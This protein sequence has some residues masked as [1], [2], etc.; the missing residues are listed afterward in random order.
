MTKDSRGRVRFGYRGYR[1]ELT[2]R[3]MTVYNRYVAYD[4]NNWRGRETVECYTQ[5][6]YRLLF[7]N[8]TGRTLLATALEALDT[9]PF[10]TAI[11]IPEHMRA[12]TSKPLRTNNQTRATR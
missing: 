10:T 7:G 9:S 6:P 11:H 3:G 8:V 12:V 5:Y 2:S 4:G 1:Y